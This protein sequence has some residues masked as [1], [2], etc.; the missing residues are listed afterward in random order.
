MKPIFG[1][2]LRLPTAA[3]CQL[4]PPASQPVCVSVSD[5]PKIRWPSSAGGSNSR[6]RPSLLLTITIHPPHQGKSIRPIRQGH[7]AR[8]EHTGNTSR[9]STF[10]QLSTPSAIDSSASKSHRSLQQTTDST[11]YRRFIFYIVNITY[12]L[13]SLSSLAFALFRTL[14]SPCQPPQTTDVPRSCNCKY[15]HKEL[16]TTGRSFL[17]YL[18]RTRF[19]HRPQPRKAFREQP[20]IH[21]LETFHTPLLH[22]CFRPLLALTLRSSAAPCRDPIFIHNH[23]FQPA[24]RFYVSTLLPSTPLQ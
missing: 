7:A 10:Q 20:T 1:S 8:S 21:S 3:A 15:I 19:S 14:R 16:L 23:R 2:H 12:I 13:V 4:S 11:I 24:K 17:A 18:S 9:S 22:L 6:F 5:R